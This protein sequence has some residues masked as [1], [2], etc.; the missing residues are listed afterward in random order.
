MIAFSLS[1]PGFGP[2][3]I[4]AELARDKWG[5]LRISPNGVWRVLRRNGLNTRARRARILASSLVRRLP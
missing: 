1:H 3:R 5:G 4:S 2:R